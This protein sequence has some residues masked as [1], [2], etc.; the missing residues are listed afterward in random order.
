MC[1]VGNTSESLLLW[2]GN[3]VERNTLWE[4]TVIYAC[5]IASDAKLEPRN[6]IN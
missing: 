3:G 5:D 4:G 1:C 6:P 2:D